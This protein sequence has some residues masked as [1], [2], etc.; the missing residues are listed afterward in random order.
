MANSVTAKT[1]Q[2]NTADV[3]DQLDRILAS[4]DFHATERQRD[5]LRF[6]VSETL[7]GRSHEVKGYTVAT[8]V[9][10]R[11]ESFDPN[12]DPI[13]SI[14]ANKLRR[15]LERYYLTQG[16]ADPI[17]IEIPKGTYVPTFKRLNANDV[18]NGNNA[19]PAS[20]SIPDRAAWPTVM[21]LP[22][23]NLTG[24]PEKEYWAIGLATEIA[25][26]LSRYQEIRVLIRPP[27]DP[28]RHDSAGDTR[29]VISGAIRTGANGIKVNVQLLDTKTYS[30]I[31]ADAHQFGLDPAEFMAFEE[32]F[33]RVVAVKIAGEHG[34]IFKTISNESR[35]IPP[36]QLKT[37]E[38]LLRYYEW[39]M[40]YS[41]DSAVRASQALEH[42]VNLE[43]HCGHIWTM[44]GRLYGGM[45]ALG[46]PGFGVTLE[47]AR[48][49]SEKGVNLI[50]DDQRARASLA[51][52]RLISDQ[53][54]AAISD[55]ERALE[56]NPNCLFVLDSI[57]Y[58]LTLLG[59]WERGPEIIRK[60]IKLNP[61]YGYYVHYALVVDLF[62]RK[63]FT[64]AYLETLNF[65]RPAMFWD[66]LLNA[67]ACGLSGRLEEGKQAVG[68]LLKLKPDFTARG[69]TLIRY[70]IKFD[71]IFDSILEGLSKVGL[72]LDK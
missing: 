22:F 64:R 54:Q 45:V 38:A 68:D 16:K 32:N 9:F 40:N 31:W 10:G 24:D 19:E 53:T 29:F 59:D 61:Y 39:S 44:R 58:L 33:A 20:P 11:D 27:G 3:L 1:S 46:I 2:L 67:A 50:P 55:A 48:A 14:Q 8:S 34:L 71:D 66:P 36:T 43:P 41:P 4:S 26:E 13:V 7:A 35:K 69:K 21:V 6:V 12:L 52:V 49:F 63:D 56:L 25:A 37:Y 23:Q 30:Q 42:A 17:L 51:Y 70:Y 28:T 47:M 18:S 5:F 57:G 60:V 15:A 65:R 72:T 62:H